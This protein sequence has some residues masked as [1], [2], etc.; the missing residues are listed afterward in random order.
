ML[1]GRQLVDRDGRSWP[2]AGLLP[3]T[4]S[5]AAPRL[6]LGY[7]EMTLLTP[8]PLGPAGAAFR[9]HEFHYAS[10]VDRHGPALFQAASTDGEEL[11]AQGCVQGRVLGSFLHLIDRR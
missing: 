5:F 8:T 3:V 9:G 10:E 2:M 6:H 1:L 11:G 7:R 4:T